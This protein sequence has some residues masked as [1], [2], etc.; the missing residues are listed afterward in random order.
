MNFGEQERNFF[1]TF[2]FLVVPG[3][4]HDELGWINSEFEQVFIDQNVVHDG[5]ARTMI[6]GFIGRRQGLWRLL[7]HPVIEDLIECLLGPEPNYIGSDGN[8]YSGDT[9]WHADGNH[10]AGTFIKVAFYLDSVGKESGALRVIPGSHRLTDPEWEARQAAA[11]QELWNVAGDLVPATV[12]PSE[13]GDLVVF[14][15]NLMHS[16]W[17]GGNR[18]PMFTINLCRQC[19][20][21]EEVAELKKYLSDRASYW[22]NGANLDV[23]RSVP[24]LDRM[25]RQVLDMR[26]LLWPDLEPV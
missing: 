8:Y 5:T 14:N 7:E 6:V 22:K 19:D 9:Q 10:K 11:S 4:V 24:N 26:S 15:H 2:G 25:L 1:E 13:P 20:R 17:G 12:L 18:R 3:A 23:V 16:S 21:P